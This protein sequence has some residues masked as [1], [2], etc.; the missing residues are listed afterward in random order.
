M[1][2]CWLGLVGS[3]GPWH[4]TGGCTGPCCWMTPVRAKNWLMDEQRSAIWVGSKDQLF[5]SACLMLSLNPAKHKAEKKTNYHQ[6]AAERE[7]EYNKMT[8]QNWQPTFLKSMRIFSQV[9][10][11]HQVKNPKKK[12]AKTLV[13]ICFHYFTNLQWVIFKNILPCNPPL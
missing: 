9:I 8:E 5:S 7:Y 3:M 11:R 4:W 12:Q 1:L 13:A 10:N 6:P 2:R